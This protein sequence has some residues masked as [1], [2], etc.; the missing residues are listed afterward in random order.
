MINYA[1]LIFCSQDKKKTA[2]A[3]RKSNHALCSVLPLFYL[4]LKMPDGLTLCSV[5]VHN[6]GEVRREIVHSSVTPHTLK[7][8]FVFWA[9]E[10]CVMF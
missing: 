2:A 1:E 9:C 6:L 3:F 10:I 8:N 4:L 5:D 7:S